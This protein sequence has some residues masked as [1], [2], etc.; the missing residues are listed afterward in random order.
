MNLSLASGSIARRLFNHPL[1]Y[2]CLVVLAADVA[3][4][5][6]T[7]AVG[8]LCLT[9]EGG[10]KVNEAAIAISCHATD[11]APIV[12]VTCVVDS[13]DSIRHLTLFSVFHTLSL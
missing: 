9:L 8:P 13:C 7:T 1:L 10:A 12:L 2:S 4:L 5:G 6:S 3:D 11:L